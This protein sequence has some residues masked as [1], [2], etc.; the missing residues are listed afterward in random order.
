M[1]FAQIIVKLEHH[2]TQSCKNTSFDFDMIIYSQFDVFASNLGALLA[3]SVA[4]P[5]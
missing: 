4:R 5:V 2:S 3:I 1:F